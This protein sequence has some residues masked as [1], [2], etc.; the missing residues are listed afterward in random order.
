MIV[1]FHVSLLFCSAVNVGEETAPFHAQTSSAADGSVQPPPKALLHSMHCF[2]LQRVPAVLTIH[3]PSS[4]LGGQGREGL[5][6]LKLGK[7]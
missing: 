1:S 6:Q 5:K 2:C 4:T 3:H 7:E